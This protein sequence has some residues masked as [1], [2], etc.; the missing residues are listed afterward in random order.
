VR[1]RDHRRTGSPRRLLL[2][3]GLSG[4]VAVLVV[5]AAG[6]Y[7]ARRVGERESIRDAR[8]LTELLARTVIEPHLRDGIVTGDP[9][10]RAELDAAVRPRVVS[11]S[12]V[13]VKLWTPA[14]RIVYSD[15]PRLVGTQYRLQED[16]LDVLRTGEVAAE[17]SD[18]TRPENRY[19]RSASK[20]LEVYLPVRTPD[21]HRLLFETYLGYGSVTAG[22]R[23]VWLALLPALGGGLAVLWLV[24]LP[25]AASLGRRLRRGQE[26]R[27]ELLLRSLDASDRERRRIAAD[28]HDGIVQDLAGASFTLAGAGQRARDEETRSILDDAAAT[29]RRAVSELRSLLVSIYP[30]N[31]SGGGLE[32]ALSDLLARVG[33]DGVSTSLAVDSDLDLSTEHEQ[34]V[35]RVAQEAL[36][37]VSAHADASRVDVE[38]ARA[39]G[40]YRLDVADDGRGFDAAGR[41]QRRAE[42]HLGLDLLAD[43]AGDAGAALEIESAP[44]AGTRVRLEGPT[45]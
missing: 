20:L 3:F 26:E 14:G 44:A 37:N 45:A 39:N 10:A 29:T 1:P 6:T 41:A 23:R 13:R 8:A 9:A 7:A 33:A 42:G 19:E 32:A 31:L 11:G 2:Q 36:R 38:L 24:Q 27:E 4:L 28:V 34:L 5:L 30:P 21:G 40:G 25:V 35:F 17:V 18:L 43:R 12:I 15:E 22:A 16:D